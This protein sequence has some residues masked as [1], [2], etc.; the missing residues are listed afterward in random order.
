MNTRDEETTNDK[1][2]TAYLRNPSYGVAQENSQEENKRYDA[3]TTG[4]IWI[5]MKTRASYVFYNLNL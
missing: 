4:K 5:K 1:V 3:C 2:P